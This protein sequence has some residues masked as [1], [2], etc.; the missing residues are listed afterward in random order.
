MLEINSIYNED[1]LIT[2][3][4]IDDKSISG[5]ICSPPYNQST[6]RSDMYYN[7]GYSEID[8]L[9]ESDY[10]SLRLNEF[11]EFERILIDDGV[12]CY[13]L[14]Y[15][16]DNPILP[17]LLMTEVHKNTNLTICDTI[18]WV[19]KVSIP[20]QTSPTKLSRIVE[21]VYVIVKKDYLHNFKTNKIVSTINKK[22]SQKFYKNY[23]NLIEAKNNDGIKT[24]L[25]ATYSTELVT[26]LIDIYFPQGSLIYDPFMGSGS[27]SLGCKMRKCDFIGSE[28]NKEFYDLSIK[29]LSN[30]TKKNKEQV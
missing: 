30:D 16:N 24:T 5:I 27:T 13:N 17:T 19:K 21:L 7:N 23:T 12:I 15:H 9:S 28:L 2:M 18:S 25:K 22:T 1:N 26:K 29:R 6:K 4:R 11:K 3:N 8:N 20:F 14:S 10:I